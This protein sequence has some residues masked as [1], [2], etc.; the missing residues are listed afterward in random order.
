M[1]NY[2]WG[3]HG[4]SYDGPPQVTPNPTAPTPVDNSSYTPVGMPAPVAPYVPGYTGGYSGGGGATPAQAAQ[5]IATSAKGDFLLNL[6]FVGCLSPVWACLYPLAAAA[7]YLALL[8]VAGIAIRFVPR[9]APV[10][11]NLI[12]SAIALV[13]A[14]I[15]IWNASRF[16]HV[17]ARF[18]AY[19]IPRHLV[20]LALLAALAVVAIQ[21]L[22]GIPISYAVS[23]PI[24]KRALFEPT[25][26]GVVLGVVVVSHFM[27]WNWKWAR[28]FWDR[29]L[30]A[31]QLRKRGA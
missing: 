7:G 28:D 25:N 8:F 11:P 20:R 29:R 31:A 3:P 30:T 27:L 17:L 14:L 23:P 22:Q 1:G 10:N 4:P 13:A 12:A 2:P 24:F 19:R 21:R 9:D 6:A 26:L 5:I 15:V 18:N 16:E